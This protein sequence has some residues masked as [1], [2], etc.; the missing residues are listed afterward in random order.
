MAAATTP[1]LN[2]N[3]VI[4]SAVVR[5][6]LDDDYIEEETFLEITETGDG[7]W[8]TNLKRYVRDLLDDDLDLGDDDEHPILGHVLEA[9]EDCWS[10]AGVLEALDWPKLSAYRDKLLKKYPE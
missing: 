1:R 8:K 3:P 5:W 2:L 6:L 4:A 9:L 7:T 10:E